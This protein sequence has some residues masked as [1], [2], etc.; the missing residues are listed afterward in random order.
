MARRGGEG[1]FVSQWESRR[2]AENPSWSIAFLAHEDE[3]FVLMAGIAAGLVFGRKAEAE[4]MSGT[5]ARAWKRAF[6]LYSAHLLIILPAAAFVAW[7]ATREGDSLL[8][9]RVGL[10]P[11]FDHTATAL[12]ATVLLGHQP[13]YLDI[14]PL[15]ITLLLLVP[16]ML[17]LAG[18]APPQLLG[19][20]G[21]V[22]AAANLLAWN[23]PTFPSEGGWMFNLPEPPSDLTWLENACD[24]C[25]HF[26]SRQ[27]ISLGLKMLRHPAR[28]RAC[29]SKAWCAKRREAVRPQPDFLLSGA[30]LLQSPAA[31]L[32]P[33]HPQAMRLA[34]WAVAPKRVRGKDRRA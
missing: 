30:A 22:W 9:G 19:G 14:L 1:A 12:I 33:A 28:N 3:G 2:T 16:V 11:L 4:G 20:S 32:C 21:A 26:P 31:P 15:C 6:E 25:S 23:T 8:L 29:A 18:R 13:N 17:P 34:G 24:I 10:G 27:V 7:V 5:M